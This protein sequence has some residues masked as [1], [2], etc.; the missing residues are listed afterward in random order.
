MRAYLKSYSRLAWIIAL[1]PL[2]LSSLS[3]LTGQERDQSASGD[4]A[5]IKA[6]AALYDGIRVET[7]P[8]GLRVYLQPIPGAPVV[9]TKVAYKVGAAD[10]DKDQTGLSHYLEHL[11]FKGTDKLIPG[12]IDRIT[13]RNGGQNNAYTNEDMTVYHFDFAADRWEAVLEIE[14]DRMRNTRID[15]KHE[16]QQ[17]KGAVIEELQ[18]NEDE[19]WDLEYKAIL[20]L[21]FGKGPYGHP[22]IGERQHVRDAT[23]ATITAYYDRWYHPN[24]A[25]L[26]IVGGF[27]PDRAMLA[28]KELFSSI[29]AGKL[30]ERKTVPP[31][32]LKR[33]ARLEMKSKFEV[34]RLM[35]GFNGVRIGEPDYY[36][37]EVIDSLLSGGKTSRLYKKLVEGERVAGAVDASNS[38]G[39]YPGWFGIQVELLKGKERA[40]VEELV[41]AELKKLADEPP[42]EAELK[43]V[44]RA[45]LASEVF[46]RESTHSLADSIARGVTTN[47]LEYLKTYLARIQAVTAKQVQLTAKKYLDPEKRVVVWSVPPGS[48]AGEGGGDKPKPAGAKERQLNRSTNRLQGAGA[49]SEIDFSFKDVQ[50]VVLPNGLTL[51]LRENRR[52][53]VFVASASVRDI[54]FAELE[55]QSGVAGLVGNLLDEGTDK[56]TGQQIAEMIEDAGGSLSLSA[57]GGTVKVLSPDRGLGLRLLLECLTRP[58]FTPEAFSREKERLL[59]AL[60]DAERQPDVRA[61]RVF[62]EEV[63]GKH[64]YG[65]PGMG[66]R[67]SVEKLTREDC[68]AHHRKTFVPNQTTLVIVGDFNAREVIEEVTRLTADWKKQSLALSA[69]HAIPVPEKFTQRVIS[70]PDAVQLQFYMGHPGIPRKN[71]DYHKLLVMDYVLGTGPGFTDRLSSR[72]RDREGLAYTVSANITSSAREQPGVFTCY[73]GTDPKNFDRAK[74]GFLEELNRIRD[75]KPKAEEVEDAKKYL[76]GSMPFQLTTNERIAGQLLT[77]ERYKL[78]FDYLNQYRKAVAAV[79]PEDVQSVAKK[80]LDP[81]RMILV[82]AGPVDEKGQPLK[83]PK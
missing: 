79:T 82:I 58:A 2:I 66:R 81:E 56:L 61:R 5:L 38:S 83:K 42:S 67:A 52:L 23:A 8:N 73:I 75:E 10:E 39:R 11:L 17:E 27:D 31:L 19:P 47:D 68:V 18:R 32:D 33:P 7:L 72:L 16:F 71:P 3:V 49:A 51:L 80:Y 54:V 1:I 76:L 46:T 37:L 63:Y 60:D 40:K 41:L 29:P 26:V 15:A 13:L 6:A 28:I 14:A 22:V 12:D 53:P 36:A 70:M 24:N 50:R 78:G 77:M 45:M 48:G 69:P 55:E 30:P 35:I 74:K 44:R 59:S 43:R 64:P 65:R 62:Y 20:P 57:S 25:A 4:A 21:L 34:P 9:T